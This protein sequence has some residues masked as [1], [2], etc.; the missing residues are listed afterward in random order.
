MTQQQK[1][2]LLATSLLLLGGFI[3]YSLTRKKGKRVEVAD[4]RHCLLSS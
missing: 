4:F 1:K 2:I 3:A